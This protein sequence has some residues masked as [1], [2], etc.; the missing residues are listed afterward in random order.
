MQV[1]TCTCVHDY[2]FCL[3][4]VSSCYKLI[5]LQTMQVELKKRE[6][7]ENVW[8]VLELHGHAEWIKKCL[9]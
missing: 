3:V 1:P 5:T 6:V 8:R 4:C 2:F 9:T 7:A